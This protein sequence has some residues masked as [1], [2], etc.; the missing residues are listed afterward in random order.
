M[1]THET[2]PPAMPAAPPA[3]HA[4]YYDITDH[5]G[6]PVASLLVLIDRTRSPV[7]AEV[8][9]YEDLPEELREWALRKGRGIIEQQYFSNDPVPLRVMQSYPW[10]DTLNVRAA[11]ALTPAVETQWFQRWQIAAA[12]GAVVLLV[13]LVWALVSALRG[14]GGE[15]AETTGGELSLAQSEQPAAAVVGGEGVTSTLA[16]PAIGADLPPSRH[17]NPNILVGSRV[18]V[19]P[20]AALN[21]TA[22]P[23]PD[24]TIVGSMANQ[25]EATVIAGPAMTQG[26]SD[27]IVWWRV[28]L[29]SSL[30]AWAPANTSDGPVL[31]LVQ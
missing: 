12:V 27:T 8:H 1:T 13:A 23:G 18:R 7:R 14:P 28:R 22:E 26:L 4:D 17:A 31:E 6:W 15:A 25:Q 5:D 2:A 21:L 9:L 3:I 16:S 11:G 10:R 20:G 19:R 30:E 24:E 29:D